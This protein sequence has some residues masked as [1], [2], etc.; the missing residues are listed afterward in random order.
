MSVKERE[1][2]QTKFI[3]NWGNDQKNLIFFPFRPWPYFSVM[4]SESFMIQVRFSY[5]I[6]NIKCLLGRNTLTGI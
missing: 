2:L 4:C 5:F 1:V 6:L 3:Q